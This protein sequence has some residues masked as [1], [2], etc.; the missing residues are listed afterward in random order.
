MFDWFRKK[1]RLERLR[2]RYTS[3]MRKSYEIALRDPKK[4]ERVHSQADKIYE[5]IQF[6]TLQYQGNE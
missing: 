4:S 1:S 6:L 2:E 5:E 3:L